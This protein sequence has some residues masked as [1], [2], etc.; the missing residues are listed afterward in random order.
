MCLG[1]PTISAEIKRLL[2]GTRF[3]HVSMGLFLA[4]GD[5]TYEVKPQAARR[6]DHLA[7]CRRSEPHQPHGISS[8]D[9]AGSAQND[10]QGDR[11]TPVRPPDVGKP[12]S[13]R[14]RA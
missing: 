10:A 7:M 13:C 1:P 6:A 4:K 14:I 2:Y 3:A 5:R 11:R 12:R 9:A 8:Q